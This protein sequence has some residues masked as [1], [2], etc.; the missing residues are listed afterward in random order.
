MR[1]GYVFAIFFLPINLTN[2]I[3]L[4]IHIFQ[5]GLSR[6]CTRN[7][8]VFQILANCGK[9]KES[10]YTIFFLLSPSFEAVELKYAPPASLLKV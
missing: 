8:T 10:M 7:S 6:N 5:I 3:T 4:Q 1:I 2:K 9:E